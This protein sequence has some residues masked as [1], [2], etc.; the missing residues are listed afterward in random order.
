MI[1][2]I[3]KYSFSILLVFVCNFII[4]KFMFSLT[5]CYTLGIGTADLIIIFFIWLDRMDI[6]KK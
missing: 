4:N 2:N 3:I 5:L 1:K 6:F